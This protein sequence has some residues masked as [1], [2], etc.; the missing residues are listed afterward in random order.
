LNFWSDY[1]IL[2]LADDYRYV[3]I[4]SSSDKYLWI[5]SR[6]PKMTQEDLDFVLA[7]A[8]QRG[9]DTSKLIWVEQK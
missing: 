3:L 5:L 7:R 9:Y 2:E 8:K 1:N 6:T 4:G